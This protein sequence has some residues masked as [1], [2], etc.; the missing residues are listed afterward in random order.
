MLQTVYEFFALS[1]LDVTPP[2]T[3]SELII[4]LLCFIVAMS[5]V[6]AVFRIIGGVLQIFCG[7]RWRQ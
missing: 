6:L 7:W 1:G 5:L 2:A 3:F 4:Y